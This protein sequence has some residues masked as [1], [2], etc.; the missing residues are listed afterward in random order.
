MQSMGVQSITCIAVVRLLMTVFV[1]SVFVVYL[2]TYQST[3]MLLML[4]PVQ[5]S[6]YFRLFASFCQYKMYACS[7]HV[8]YPLLCSL[9]MQEHCWSYWNS[10]PWSPR[11][12]GS[13]PCSRPYCDQVGPSTLTLQ[14]CVCSTCVHVCMF[15]C[16]QCNCQLTFPFHYNLLASVAGRHFFETLSLC[17]L[18][19]QMEAEWLWECG[20]QGREA[21]F[22]V[23]GH[24]E[25][26]QQLLGHSWGELSSHTCR[27]HV[28]QWTHAHV[29]AAH[30]ILLV[31]LLY[32]RASCTN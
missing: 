29:G 3:R 9:C 14:M 24:Q 12:L 13:Q 28:P 31:L 17:V 8:V 6:T 20:T 32:L 23:C 10:W 11:T 1:T 27:W 7:M 18:Y 26:G 16:V 19:S 22:G 25:K 30:I 4:S 15:T 5:F 2:R 21:C